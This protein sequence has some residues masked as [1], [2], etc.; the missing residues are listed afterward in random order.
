MAKTQFSLRS[1]LSMVA[2]VSIVLMFV[3]RPQG[4]Q[5]GLHLLPWI[6]CGGAVGLITG[7][8]IGHDHNDSV[9]DICLGLTGAVLLWIAFP[10]I[11]R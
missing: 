4:T 5:G 3:A 2:A 1:L 9:A 7:T 10:G 6:S 8:L 11:H